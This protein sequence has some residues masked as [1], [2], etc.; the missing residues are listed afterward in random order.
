MKICLIESC[1]RE[2][3]KRKMCLAHYKR[4]KDQGDNFDR[5]SIVDVSNP[6][7]RFN[8]KLGKPNESGCIEW[9]GERRYKNGYGI[10][11]L[12]D[13]KTMGAHRKAYEI[14]NGKIP[15]GLLI[16]HRCDNP[17]CCNVNHLFL[18][19][20]SD[21]MMDMA[22]KGRHPYKRGMKREPVVIGSKCGTAKLNE[23]KVREIKIKLNN[24]IKGT[25]IARKY[26]IVDQVIYDIKHGRSWKHI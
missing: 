8:A 7:S 23:D 24:G 3:K 1:D 25:V 14:V 21:N 17:P 4:W 12:S 9:L 26:G 10:F 19:T 6:I 16:C 18:G 13:G 22:N 5:S 15:D 11:H 2:A 20:A